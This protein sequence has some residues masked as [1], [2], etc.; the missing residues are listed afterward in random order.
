MV[1]PAAVLSITKQCELLSMS[2]GLFYYLPVAWT[3][4]DLHVMAK[5][6]ELFTENPTRGTRRLRQA[7]KK[8]WGLVAGRDKVRRLRR[9]MGITAIYPKKT[10]SVANQ[11]HK[12]DPYLLRGVAITHPNQVWS[13]RISPISACTKALCI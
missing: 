4:R 7:L 9:I 12:K 13:T 1:E 3:A 6:D 5:L 2:R 8:R 11:A 10:L